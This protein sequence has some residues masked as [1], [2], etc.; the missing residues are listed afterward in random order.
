M[1]PVC[2]YELGTIGQYDICPCCGTEFRLHDESATHAELR[3]VWM[4]GGC[5]WWSKSD[6]I[7]A[8]WNPY[9]QINRLIEAG[10]A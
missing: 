5:Q 6:P 2:G 10:M 9:G 3:T 7:P 1:C 4:A 8:M